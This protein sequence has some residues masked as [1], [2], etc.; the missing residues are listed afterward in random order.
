MMIEVYACINE[1]LVYFDAKKAFE[2]D[3]KVLKCNI[4][5]FNKYFKCKIQNID[6]RD[7]IFQNVEFIY[8]YKNQ[9][10]IYLSLDNAFKNSNLIVKYKLIGLNKYIIDKQEEIKR[11]KNKKKYNELN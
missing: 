8:V 4:M 2:E 10:G 9:Y 5:D 3:T 6:F 11:K 7:K 1:Q